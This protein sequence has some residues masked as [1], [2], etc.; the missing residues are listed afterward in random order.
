M[1]ILND[2]MKGHYNVVYSPDDGG[3]YVEFWDKD[4]KDPPVFRTKPE[5]YDWAAK[6]GGTVDHT[7]P[8]K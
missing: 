7:Q 4:I 3:Y 2:E 1:N 8:R 6:N 5:A